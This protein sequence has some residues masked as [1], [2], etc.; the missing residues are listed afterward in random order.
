MFGGANFNGWEGLAPPKPPPCPRFCTR[1]QISMI[2]VSRHACIKQYTLCLYLI[3]RTQHK[4][5]I[6]LLEKKTDC[7]TTLTHAIDSAA[8]AD[9]GRATPYISLS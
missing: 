9:V 6:H 1:S 7:V 2:K 8:D 5:T 4:I 3:G